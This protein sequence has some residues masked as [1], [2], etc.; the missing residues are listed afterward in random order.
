MSRTPRSRHSE[1]AHDLTPDEE[2]WAEALA[3]IRIHG[4]RAE[5]FISERVASL[6]AQGQA[7]GVA[8]L[9]AIATRITQLRAGPV[10]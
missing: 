5:A 4:D 8:R 7:D 9:E 10:H 2:R 1:E 3:I 6:A